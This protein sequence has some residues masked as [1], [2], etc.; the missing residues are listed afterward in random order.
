MSLRSGILLAL[1]YVLV[2]S[3]VALLVPLGLSLRDRVDA[4]IRL[5]ARTQAETVAAQA[6]GLLSPART[7]RLDALAERSS[8]AV[9]GRV[10][11]VDRRGRVLADSAGFAGPGSR[12]GSR[13]EIAAALA[14]DPGQEIRRSDDLGKEILATAVP[15]YSRTRP[16][17]AVRV[18]QSVNDVN[19]AIRRSWLGLGLI[20]ALVIGLG[21]IAG[22][23]IA[24]RISGPIVRLDGA[25]R[26]VARGD[27]EV[28]ATVEGSTEQRTLARSFNTMTERLTVLLASQRDFVA[29]ASHQ[30]RTPLTGLRLRIEEIRADANGAV[31]KENADAALAEVDR[32]SLIVDELLELSQAGE[33][34][35]P[36]AR[37]DLDRAVVDAGERW[38][39][40]AAE[41]GCRLAVEPGGGGEVRCH[42]TELDRILDILLENAIA[43]APGEPVEIASAP[44]SVTVSDRGPGLQGQRQEELF[45]RFRRGQ[46]S[47][48]GPSGTG[49]GLA[50]ARELA[51]RWDASLELSDG[52][53]AG[54]AAVLE[55][56]GATALPS[57]SPD[58]PTVEA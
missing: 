28:R 21:L 12:Y 27:L 45:E 18:T 9:G 41:A 15:V 13:P 30:L 7:G 1:A 4:E 57:L 58:V 29:D 6:A 2:L 48:T 47:G 10:L 20:G 3:V 35:P 40:A 26:R 55:F 11:I 54:L 56:P 8:V 42:A 32:L 50:I 14:G 22:L 37:A 43:Y 39:G 46:A 36:D 5:E 33:A 31:E 49:L 16:S 23:V 25:A 44:G 52:A 51:L 53:D 34:P 19:E 38:E 17:G 24:R